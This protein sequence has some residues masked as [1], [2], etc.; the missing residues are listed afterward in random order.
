MDNDGDIDVVSADKNGKIHI[1]LNES[2]IKH[3]AIAPTSDGKFTRDDTEKTI[4]DLTTGLEWQDSEINIYTWENALSY[5][6]QKGNGWRLPSVEALFTIAD[7]SI[8]NPSIDNIFQYKFAKNFWTS[9]SVVKDDTK[10]WVI[11]FNLALDHIS[12]EKTKDRHVRCVKGTPLKS[13]FIRDD[14][15][16][17]VI[18][19]LHKLMWEDSSSVTTGKQKW[20]NAKDECLNLKLASYTNWRLPNI[21]ELYTIVDRTKNN[22]ATKDAFKNSISSAF[23]SSTEF[24]T[25]TYRH[26]GFSDG[27]DGHK[28]VKKT[29]YT[30]CVRDME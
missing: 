12:Y 3:V 18:D 13:I 30:R 14:N 6:K 26:I 23:W 17:V 20:N 10:A 24:E 5:C 9:T 28:G 25:D 8:S 4:T 11:D 15:R 1:Y 27:N 7:K 21:N 16:K 19:T 29:N 22:P 2:P